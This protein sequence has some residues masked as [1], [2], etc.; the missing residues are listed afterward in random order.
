MTFAEKA[1]ELL[2]NVQSSPRSS[3]GRVHDLRI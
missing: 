1:H 2:E 3:V